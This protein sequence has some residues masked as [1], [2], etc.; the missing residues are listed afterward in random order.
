M[1][2]SPAPT[3]SAGLSAT[4]AEGV[5]GWA[6][7]PILAGIRSGTLDTAVFRHYLEQDY[8]YL[9]AY[10]R[11]YSRLAAN[12]TDD[13]TLEYF[14]ALAHGVVT[15]ELDHHKR[16]A[17]PFGCDFASV[18]PSRET[19]DY[20]AF[21]DSFH[22]DAAGMLVAMLPCIQGYGLALDSL[23]EAASGPY[24]DWIDI[25]TG[26]DYAALVDR[27]LAMID[28]APLTVERAHSIVGDA[29]ELERRFW[30]QHPE[31]VEAST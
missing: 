30:N 26:A 11:H 8:L 3:L 9:K 28:T 17:E 15:V 4:I 22:A 7:L 10:A 31:T 1:T 12:S 23:R 2:D 19:L 13:E 20:L 18:R 25:Y 16:A 6:D 24:R 29:L 21:Y 14:V 5:A 27:H